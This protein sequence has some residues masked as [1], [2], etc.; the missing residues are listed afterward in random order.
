M[1]NDCFGFLGCNNAGE[2]E[3]KTKRLCSE[4]KSPD[5]D[6][7]LTVLFNISTISRC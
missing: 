3:S 7:F 1:K 6:L 4:L 2:E 5:L